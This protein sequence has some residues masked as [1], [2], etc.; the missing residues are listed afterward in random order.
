MDPEQADR[1]SDVFSMVL[2]PTITEYDGFCS[3]SLLIDRSAGLGVSSVTFDSRDAMLRSRANAS[4]LREKAAMD[5]APKS[6]RSAS[7][8]WPSRTCASPRDGL[9]PRIRLREGSHAR[10]GRSHD[11]QECPRGGAP[12]ASRTLP[13]ILDTRRAAPAQPCRVGR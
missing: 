6:W 9:S 11:R 3:V 1:L 7:S 4:S 5:T 10:P 8:N 13:A 2:M 12:A